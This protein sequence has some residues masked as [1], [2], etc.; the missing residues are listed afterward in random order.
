[1]VEQGPEVPLGSER[2][3]F[4]FFIATLRLRQ[5][6]WGRSE[7]FLSEKPDEGNI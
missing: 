5:A 6:V 4:G 1:V 3:W 7:R 2:G